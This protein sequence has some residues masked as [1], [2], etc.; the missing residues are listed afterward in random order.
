MKN[1]T[2]KAAA[3]AS[4]AAGRVSSQAMPISRTTP[5]RTADSLRV[6]P[7]PI[8]EAAVITWVVEIGA[9]TTNAVR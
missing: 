7:T 8:T 3:A 5:Q 2:G 9:A 4:P 6:A 1:A